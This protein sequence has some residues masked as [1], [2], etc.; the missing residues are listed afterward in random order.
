MQCKSRSLVLNQISEI[1]TS[2]LFAPAASSRV[3]KSLGSGG[4]SFE[5]MVGLEMSVGARPAPAESAADSTA[6]KYGSPI[7][8]P[9]RQPTA[10]K[11]P[12]SRTFFHAASRFMSAPGTSDANRQDPRPHCVTSNNSGHA[13]I[14]A[15]RLVRRLKIF[16]SFGSPCRFSLFNKSDFA[17]HAFFKSPTDFADHFGGVVP[18]ASFLRSVL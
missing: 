7:S 13:F 18:S 9:A 4:G 10:P 17:S 2:P 14:P 6:C 16:S 3:R 8:Q 5:G 12:N 1:C 11:K 15:R